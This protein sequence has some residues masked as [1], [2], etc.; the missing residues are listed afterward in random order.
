MAKRKSIH[1]Y[2]WVE[3]PDEY[4]GHGEE[5]NFEKTI[6]G[7]LTTNTINVV[8]N[9]QG[10]QLQAITWLK[11]H[12]KIDNPTEKVLV[13]DGNQFRIV[14]IVNNIGNRY[15][16]QIEQLVGEVKYANQN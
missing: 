13:I 10:T 14:N 6:H 1:I 5:L 4:G 15:F 12:N 16:Y 7:T 9:Q 3:V 8:T 11:V 2:K